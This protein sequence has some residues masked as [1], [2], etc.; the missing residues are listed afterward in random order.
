MEQGGGHGPAVRKRVP[1]IVVATAVASLALVGGSVA[2]VPGGARYSGKTDAGMDVVL[3]TSRNGS[4]IA[5]VVIYYRVTCDDNT[6]TDTYTYILNIPIAARGRFNSSN[7]YVGSSD[8]S[9]NRFK[10]R[11]RV[12]STRAG[13]TFSVTVDRKAVGTAGQVRC[14]SGSVAWTAGRVR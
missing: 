1:I 5:R 7:S 4:K 2:K 14:Q 9:M 11:G 6:S 3:R 13:G 12:G 8:H 10:L